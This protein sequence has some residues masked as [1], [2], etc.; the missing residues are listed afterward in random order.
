MAL[1]WEWNRSCGTAVIEQRIHDETKE[2][3]MTLYEGNAYLIMLHEFNENGKEKYEMF[4]F[5]LDKEHMQRMLGI[6]NRGKRVDTNTLDQ[7]Y[8]RLKSIRLD[9]SRCQNVVEIAKALLQAFDDISIK[10]YTSEK[11]GEE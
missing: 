7:P 4:S 2:Y 3:D 8:N 10:V 5:W 1:R 9:K 6:S 11:K